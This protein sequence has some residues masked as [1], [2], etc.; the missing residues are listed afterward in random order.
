MDRQRLLT[1]T[2]F[3]NRRIFVF[4]HASVTTVTPHIV[5]LHLWWLWYIAGAFKVDG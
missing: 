2:E 1:C 5:R 3:P 4:D